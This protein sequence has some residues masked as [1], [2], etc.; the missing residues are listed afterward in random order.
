MTRRLLAREETLAAALAAVLAAA[1]LWAAPPGV[2]WAAHAYQRTFLLEHGF[3][4]WNN[5]W[6]AGRY[7]FVTYSVLYYPLAALVGIRV[8]AVLVGRDGRS[9]SARSCSA[10]WGR[11]RAREP[12]IRRPL[13]GDRRLRG[14]PVR[15]RR[16]R[17]RCWRS[18]RFRPAGAAGSPSC[19]LLT[20]AASPLGIHVPRRSLLGGAALARRTAPR[21][22]SGR[23]D[24]AGCI[25]P[26]SCSGGCSATAAASRTPL[27][28]APS[29]LFG[30]ARPRRSRAGARRRGSLRGL[31]WIYLVACIVAYLV[32]SAVGSNIERIRYVALPLA[33]LAAALRRLAAA[34]ARRARA[35]A[36][37]GL[38]HDADRLEL[39]RASADPEA[40][41]AYWQP[42]IAYLRANLEPVLPR[43]GR[44]HRRALAGRVPARR[45]DPDRARLVPAERLPAERAAL[46]LEA[47]RP[48]RTARGSAGWRPLRRPHRRAGRLQLAPEAAL[49][50][51]G[52]SGLVPVYRCSA[53]DG[54]RVAARNA[55]RHRARAA[56]PCSGCGR[57]PRRR[58][59]RSRAATGCASAG[60]RTGVRRA[61]ASATVAGRADE[62]HCARRP[63]SSSCAS[64]SSVEP[65]AARRSRG[66]IP[67]CSK[68]QD[69]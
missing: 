6:Y 27:Q 29:L 17:S 34:V 43:R 53:H 14:V 58:R 60:R 38:E 26:S 2:D 25:A 21:R 22:A 31:F 49:I 63:A 28:L 41:R 11:A 4:I 44:R 46:R 47:R 19:A 9:P 7:S 45:G 24:R 40:A 20:L 5:F 8:L 1:L 16:S 55:A 54:V 35:R 18:G 12:H 59:R 37:R 23:R 56:P 52:R 69:H 15:A 68:T 39:A 32:P 64:G 48:R 3:A 57:A 42:A 61:G 36:R 65:R 30:G 10:Q 13:G 33:F 67:G 66:T 62:D 51:S 50:R